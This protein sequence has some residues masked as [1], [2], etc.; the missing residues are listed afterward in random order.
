MVKT[1]KNHKGEDVSKSQR[2]NKIKENDPDH[3]GK[4]R[5]LEFRTNPS[6]RVKNKI[7]YQE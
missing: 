2:H 3:K 5:P 4:H 7:N 6:R 1:I